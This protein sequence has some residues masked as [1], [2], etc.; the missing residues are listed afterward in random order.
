[1]GT[2]PAHTV[3]RYDQELDRLRGMVARMG[4]L[5]ERQTAQAIAAVVDQN[6]EAALEPPELDV[7][8]D[9]LEREA[10]ALAIRILA[11]RAPM[12]VD[13]R[14]IIAV[15]KIT[16]DLE[17]IGD[18]ASSIAR[19][20]L[21]VEPL[22]GAMSFSALRSMGRLVQENLHKAIDAMACNDSERAMEV[23]N[24]D[25]AVDEL[26]TAMFR[27]LVTYMMEDPRKIGPCIHLLFV[28]KNLERIGDHATNIAER[29]YYA[30]TGE[31]L[32][33]VRPRGG[34]ARKGAQL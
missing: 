34:A 22:D 14:L 24:A 19:R 29:V 12:A 25:T 26:Y 30:V 8:V 2:E 7:E 9:A 16:G 32:P 13:L 20:A 4:G 6:E 17:R 1:M 11:L 3:T 5:V 28:A 15:L 33:A 10:E 21:K 31:M 18:Y 27:E 23:W